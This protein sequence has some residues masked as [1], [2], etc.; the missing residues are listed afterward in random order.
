M[1]EQKEDTNDA[2][3]ATSTTTSDATKLD[4]ASTATATA[5]VKKGVKFDVDNEKT[6]SKQAGFR[7]NL[8]A[9][10]TEWN[11]RGIPA[12]KFVEDVELFITKEGVDC[13]EVVAELRE[14]HG[15][16]KV[17]EAQALTNK[18]RMKQ[19]IPDI[20][21][22]L[23]M[24]KHLQQDQEK[25]KDTGKATKTDFMMSDSI[26]AE[27]EIDPEGTVC[28]WLGANVMMEYTFKEAEDLLE[29]NLN[30]AKIKLI[31][32]TEDNKFLKEQITIAEVSIARF[33]NH[34]VSMNA[35]K[36]KV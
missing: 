19:K 22:A 31:E 26:F 9:A 7:F 6:A 3:T 36:V 5:A 16:Y 1:E 4:G 27:A 25:N 17:L 2:T 14:I 8:A 13:D 21:N 18:I 10:E 20:E 35:K 24:V 33:Y 32:A 30:Q 34:R 12:L 23:E 29:I 15:R 28:L 11:P